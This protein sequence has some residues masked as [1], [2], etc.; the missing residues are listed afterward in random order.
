MLCGGFGWWDLD[1]PSDYTSGFRVIEKHFTLDRSLPGPDHQASLEPAELTS[2]IENIRDVERALGDGRKRPQPS[3]RDT[4]AVARKSIVTVA[5]I[6]AGE[7]IGPQHVA[8]L[9]PGTGI[10]PA[11]LDRVVGRRAARGLPAETLLA[12]EDL[13]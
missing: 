13:E 4:A 6:N 1:I 8:A 2:L 5:T 3:E 12:W 11:Y 7:R 10:S 9:R